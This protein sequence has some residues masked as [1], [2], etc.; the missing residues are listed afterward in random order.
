MGPTFFTDAERESFRTKGDPDWRKSL[1]AAKIIIKARSGGKLSPWT[2]R[3]AGILAN[4]RGVE[5]RLINQGIRV[6]EINWKE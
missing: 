2:R 5:N 4:D 3:I 1:L 6:L